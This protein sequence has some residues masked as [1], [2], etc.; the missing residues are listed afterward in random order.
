MKKCL[1]CQQE[2]EDYW[3]SFGLPGAYCTECM[4]KVVE[5]HEY[6]SRLIDLVLENLK[7]E[8]IKMRNDDK[9][10]RAE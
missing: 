8:F 9:R 7:K 10:L 1:R 3:F 5:D 2:I 6:L 4:D